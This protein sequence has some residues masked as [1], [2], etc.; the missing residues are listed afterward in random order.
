MPSATGTAGPRCRSDSIDLAAHPAVVASARLHSRLTLRDWGLET[1][2]ETVIQVV[3]EIVCNSVTATRNAGLE[4][5]IR[6]TLTA[7]SGGIVVAVWDAVPSPP[8]PATPD[9]DSEHGRGLLIVAALS[10]SYDVV[11]VSPA[12]GAG[13]FVRARIALPDAS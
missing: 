12:P 6:L 2:S 9:L 13:K 10:E 8:V 3:S 4:T 7:D 5:G 11:P 1:A